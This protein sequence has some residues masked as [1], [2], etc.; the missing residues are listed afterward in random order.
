MSNPWIYM[1]AAGV[2]AA[3]GAVLAIWHSGHW[4]QTVI[5]EL[6]RLHRRVGILE[7]RVGSHADPE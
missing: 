7:T 4:R 5:D 3:L 6:T 2:G 1:L